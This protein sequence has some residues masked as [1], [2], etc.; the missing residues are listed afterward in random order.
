MYKNISAFIRIDTNVWTDLRVAA[1][2]AD[3]VSARLGPSHLVIPAV[4]PEGRLVQGIGV[5][6]LARVVK[7]RGERNACGGGGWLRFCWRP[8]IRHALVR[9]E[10]RTLFVCMFIFCH[11]RVV[12]HF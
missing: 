5:E 4:D 8:F 1:P 9:D 11:W 2:L 3:G 10:Q 7:R 12:D 6:D